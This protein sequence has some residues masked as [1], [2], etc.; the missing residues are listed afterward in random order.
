MKF[1]ILWCENF[2]LSLWY[3]WLFICYF[4]IFLCWN[5]DFIISELVYN[6]NYV[7]VDGRCSWLFNVR[8]VYLSRWVWLMCNW[9]C[10]GCG[11]KIV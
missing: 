6:E 5:F 7:S 1:F 3:L 9:I 4:D 11:L 10:E 2:F 8:Y